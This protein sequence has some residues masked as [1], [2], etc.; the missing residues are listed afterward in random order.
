MKQQRWYRGWAIVGSCVLSQL[1]VLGLPLNA[2]SLFLHDWSAQLGAPISTLQLTQPAFGVMTALLCPVVGILADRYPSRWLFGAAIAAAAAFSI[3]MSAIDATWQLFALYALVLPFA[4]GFGGAIPSNALVSRW[5]QR[6][7]GLAM[8]LTAFGIGIGG[9]VLPPVV[10]ALMP[11][12][13]WQAI[14]RGAGVIM[15]LAVLPLLMAILRDHPQFE[16]DG[17]KYVDLESLRG[18]STGDGAAPALRSRDILRRRNFWLLLGAFLAMLAAYEGVIMNLAPIARSHGYD[19]RVAGLLIAT[20]SVVRLLA[21]LCGGLVADRVGNRIPLAA[22]GVIGAV[23]LVVTGFAGDL[24]VLAIGFALSGVLGGIW[25][26]LASAVSAEFSPR[27]YGR[28]FG[29]ISA[30]SPIGLSAGF[31]V[32]KLQEAQGDYTLAMLISAGLAGAGVLIALAIRETHRG[33]S[34]ARAEIPIDASQQSV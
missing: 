14:W 21:T 3:A 30:F 10:A 22:I 33:A 24:P 25:T 6:K 11:A 19:T 26:P 23:G 29:L 15:L 4:A 8:G 20:L 18:G 2:F 31:L 5:F 28:A 9:V 13:G 1:V 16:R 34:D 32:A 7:V 12:L 17:D 27:N